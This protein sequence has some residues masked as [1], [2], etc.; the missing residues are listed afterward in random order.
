MI[1]FGLGGL[2][3]LEIQCL[4]PD[5]KAASQMEVGVRGAR[6][7]ETHRGKTNLLVSAHASACMKDGADTRPSKDRGG[8]TVGRCTSKKT[9]R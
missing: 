6:G 4:R 3:L 1:P 9:L 8:R 2:L 7:W 5:S